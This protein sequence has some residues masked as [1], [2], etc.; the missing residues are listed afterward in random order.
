[1]MLMAKKSGARFVT[2][3]V[4]VSLLALVGCGRSGGFETAKVK[5]V[6]TLDGKPFTA[7]GTVV[8]E[9]E[10]QGKMAIGSIEAD[11]TFNLTTYKKGDGAIVGRHRV[12][13][14]PLIGQISDKE[15]ASGSE[16]ASPI[17]HKYQ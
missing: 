10:R 4:A 7:G 13:V 9:P 3:I 12:A 15:P 1:M 11:G 5:G 14:T 16:K 6:V 8:F 2:V 17:P